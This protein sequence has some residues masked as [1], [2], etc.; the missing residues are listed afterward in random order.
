MFQADPPRVPTAA[1]SYYTNH[2]TA[3]LPATELMLVSPQPEPE[4][5]TEEGRKN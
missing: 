1:G 2:E 3:E 4:A 5:V